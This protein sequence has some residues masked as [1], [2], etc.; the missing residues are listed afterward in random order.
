MDIQPQK[1]WKVLLVG[2]SC[3]DVYHYG[4][5]ERMSPEAPVPVFKETKIEI[6][7]GMSS[8]V[9]N[10]LES[11]G[12]DVIHFSNEEKIKKHR[13]IET[14]YMQQVFRSDEGESTEIESKVPNF[15]NISV[16]AVVISDY[17]KGF[18]TEDLVKKIINHFSPSVPIF[19]DSKK[20]DLTIFSK[21]ILKINNHEEA[22]AKINPDQEVVVT[23]GGLGA[24]WNSEI[25]KA[26]MVDVYD[27]CGAGDVF[28]SGLVYG[29][30]AFQSMPQAIR[31]ANKCASLSVTKTGT[32][33]LEDG[34]LKKI[35]N[36]MYGEK[37]DLYI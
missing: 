13:F 34:D 2:D 18:V 4:T 7:D 23:L 21:C 36:S 20:K 24:K 9:R 17:N 26:E 33:V 6:R 14:R 11:F 1:F 25:Y 15:E 35:I 37:H 12:L 31:I 16:D 19:V 5:C 8:N 10:N 28:L 29:W 32:Y 22:E 27:V 3:E 30:L